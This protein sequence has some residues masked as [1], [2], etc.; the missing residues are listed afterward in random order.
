MKKLLYLLIILSFVFTSCE[1]LFMDEDPADNAVSNFESLWSDVNRKYSF[2][3]YKMIDWDSIHNVYRPLVHDGMPNEDLFNVMFSMLG[4][5]RDGHVNLW[6]PF[7]VSRYE[8]VFLNSPENYDSRLLQD[9]YLGTDYMITGSLAH[10]A[11][12]TGENIGYIR[13]GSFM[14]PIVEE[15]IDYVIDRYRNK[16]GI[17]IDV[18]NNGGGAP[19]YAFL[20]A[21]RFTNVKREVYISY[22]KNGPKH[23][24]FS[25]ANSVCVEPGG[26][27]QFTKP[28]MVLTN[29]GSYSAT[30]MFVAM[31]HAFPNVRLVGDTTG[32]GGGAPTYGELPNGWGYRFSASKTILPNGFNIEN[33]IPPNIA[34]NMDPT[35]EL[36]GMDSILERALDEIENN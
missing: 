16:K 18:R 5:L 10:K 34:I 1:K 12:G 29:R 3:E 35:D 4:V 11:I 21:S 17:I 36:N 33:G 15:D 13:Y 7:N 31:M 28:V 24:D 32:G 26:S 8:A 9:H 2:F 23:N 20:L 30:N 22:V 25:S 14:D 27:I 6:S 19:D